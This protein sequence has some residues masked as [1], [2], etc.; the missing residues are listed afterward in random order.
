[1]AHPL[2]DLLPPPLPAEQ[3]IA[4]NRPKADLGTPRS[5]TWNGW[6]FDVP[7]GVFLPGA[8]SRM[9]HQRVLDGGIEVR[10]LRYVAMGA[11]LGVEA[12]AAGLRGAR[13]VY[14]VDV[15]PE[16][17]AT[18]RRHYERLVGDRPGTAFHAVV[19]D[20]F[21]GFPEGARADVVT[22]NPPAVSQTVSDD[23]DV[24]RNVCAGAPVLEAFFAQI[25]ERDL[26][27][28][29]GQ[30]FVIASN[31]ADL[32]RIVESA[33]GHGFTPEVHHRHD[34]EDGVLTYLF[35]LRREARA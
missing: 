29:G 19:A 25:A 27:A 5:Y 20:V 33:V 28:P 18:A 35:R 21:D 8:T 22:F 9:I 7:P 12:V 16:S 17:V 23:P 24:V 13:E 4:L 6:D 14:A 1:M 3:I 26:L 10:G 11:G 2:V 32:R 30:V 15:H 34:W 31:T